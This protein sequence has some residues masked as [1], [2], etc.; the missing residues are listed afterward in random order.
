MLGFLV[1]WALERYK[2]DEDTFEVKLEKN[3]DA[4]LQNTLAITRLEVQLT[5]I[6]KVLELVPEMRRDIDGIGSKLRSL[7]SSEDN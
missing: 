6:V 7:S 4:T 3:T 2:R 5:H 1:K